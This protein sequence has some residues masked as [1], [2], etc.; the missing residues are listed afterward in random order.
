M[1]ELVIVYITATL[2]AFGLGF[3]LGVKAIYEFVLKPGLER[4]ILEIG[5]D[6]YRISKFV[7]RNTR[8]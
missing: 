8:I 3:Y 7:Q 2:L 5:K 6:A 4:G 1:M